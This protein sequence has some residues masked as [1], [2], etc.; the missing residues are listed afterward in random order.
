MENFKKIFLKGSNSTVTIEQVM[1][2]KGIRIEGDK[3]FWTKDTYQNLMSEII[4]SY[5]SHNHTQNLPPLNQ[6]QARTPRD[7]HFRPMV[8]CLRNSPENGEEAKLSALV[9]GLVSYQKPYQIVKVRSH[10]HILI[11][12]GY[13]HEIVVERVQTLL[14]TKSDVWSGFIGSSVFDDTIGHGYKLHNKQQVNVSDIVV[15]RDDVKKTISFTSKN[16]KCIQSFIP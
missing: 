13:L 3:I 9:E 7:P 12:V 11:T 6:V 15:V 8:N 1:S 10:H 5:S 2:K 4:S 16:R 14:E